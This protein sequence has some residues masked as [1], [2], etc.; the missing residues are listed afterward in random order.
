MFLKYFLLWHYYNVFF[1]YQQSVQND[2]AMLNYVSLHEFFLM[3][4]VPQGTTFGVAYKIE[5]ETA[6]NYL[7]TREVELGG[8]VSDI[9]PF[10]SRE[11]GSFPVMVY[12]ATSSS[13]EWSGPA[14]MHEIATQI[15]NCSGPTG[16]TKY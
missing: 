10:H 4:F 8:Y 7:N 6:L 16:N 11:G 1:F 2:F 9:V 3:K 5:G 15:V 14:P 13:R 12:I